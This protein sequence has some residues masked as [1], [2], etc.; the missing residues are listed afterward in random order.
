MAVLPREEVN[1]YRSLTKKQ[2]EIQKRIEWIYWRNMQKVHFDKIAIAN[3]K[4]IFT[5]LGILDNLI[6]FWEYQKY[7][8]FDNL[9]LSLS[10]VHFIQNSRMWWQFCQ[11]K[12]S[13][14]YRSLY[15]RIITKI[16]EKYLKLDIWFWVCQMCILLII[17]GCAGS[18]AKWR[19]QLVQKLDKETTRGNPKEN[20]T[21]LLEKYAK[22]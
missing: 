21:D 6:W 2:R 11:V 18:V 20:W 8:K 1:W 4:P 16:W 3:L 7:L 14:G 13:T 5:F 22:G 10:N 17:R 12:R 15:R 19:G 9:T